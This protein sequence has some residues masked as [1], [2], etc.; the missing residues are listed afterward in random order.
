MAASSAD[1]VQLQVS[2]ASGMWIGDATF[3][4]SDPQARF[5]SGAKEVQ[6]DREGDGVADFSISLTGITQAEMLTATDF[7]F[8]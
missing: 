2:G 7:L 1:L 8:A 6:V 4:G 5:D 3:D